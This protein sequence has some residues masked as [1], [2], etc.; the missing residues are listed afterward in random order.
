MLIAMPTRFWVENAKWRKFGLSEALLQGRRA[1]LV[2]PHMY[3]QLRFRPLA[4]SENH[5]L[6]AAAGAGWNMNIE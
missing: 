4:T 2:A 6:A 1:C 3:Q 5:T